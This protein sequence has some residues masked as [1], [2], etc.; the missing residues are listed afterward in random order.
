MEVLAGARDV[1]V[2]AFDGPLSSIKR[3]VMSVEEQGDELDVL[4]VG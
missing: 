2:F 1:V 3:V 4:K